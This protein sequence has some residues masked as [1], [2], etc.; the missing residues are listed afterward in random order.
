M[1]KYIIKAWETEDER[2][3]GLSD[4]LESNLSDIQKT[5]EK[6]KEIKKELEELEKLEQ[7][8]EKV[9]GGEKNGI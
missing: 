4:I 2:E 8:D 7:E 6:A 5:I 1:A 9:L 3:Q